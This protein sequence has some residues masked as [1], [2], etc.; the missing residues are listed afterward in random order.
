[1]GT[2]AVASAFPSAYLQPDHT[3]D[4]GFYTA[5]YIAR[6]L[7]HPDVTVG[8]VKAWRA[9]TRKHEAY[10]ARDVLGAEFRTFWDVYKAGG[11]SKIFWM[12]P[13]AQD[14]V[15]GW[16]D[17]G[18][19]AALSVNRIPEMGHAVALLCAD[20]DGVMLH[21]SIYGHI[22]EPWGWLLGPGPKQGRNGW[23]GAAP[24]GRAFYGCHFVEGWYRLALS[25]APSPQEG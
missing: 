5:A 12:G 14:W 23:P 2:L 10:Y 6:C 18:W 19:I 15:R 22:T 13:S 8:Q 9:E 1:M 21:D 7:G 16:L 4:C 24:D 25:P 11:E 17:A 20:G 3:M